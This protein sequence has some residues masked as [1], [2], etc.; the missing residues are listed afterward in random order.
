MKISMLIFFFLY[1]S[2][3]CGAQTK[4]PEYANFEKDEI[5]LKVCHF[6]KDA[7][8]V[9][10]FDKA[11]AGYNDEHNLVT[12]RRIRFKILREKGIEKA[13]IQIRYYSYENFET[14]RGLQASIFNI[15]DEKGQVLTTLDKK[16]VYDKKLNKYYSELSFTMPKVKVG[17]IIDYKYESVM[18]N[19]GALRE[20][21]FQQEIP[22]MLSSYHLSIIPN[23]E[24]AWSVYKRTSIPIDIK[25]D[26]KGGTILFEMKNLPGL[27]NEA[28][29]ASARDYLQRVNFQFS[30][31]TNYYGKQNYSTTWKELSKELLEDKDFGSQIT[32]NLSNSDIIKSLC[33]KASSPYEKMRI[34]H[35]YVRFNINWNNIYSKYATE[36]IKEPWEKKTGNSGEINL[37]LINL[38]KSEGLD[39][40][41]L[42]V[43]ERENGKIDSTYPFVDQFNKVAA[44]VNI[45]GKGYILDGTDKQTPSYMVP[46]EFLNTIAF[47]VAKKNSTLITIIDP[48]RKKKNTIVLKGDIDVSG[49]MKGEVWVNNYDYSRLEKK[50]KYFKNK[51]KYKDEEFLKPYAAVKID[52]FQINDLESDSLPLKHTFKL[53]YTLDKSGDYYLLNYNLFTGFEKNPFLAEQRFS[54]IDFGCKY[55][56]ILDGNF[57]LPQNLVSESIPKNMKLVSP[58]NSMSVSRQIE[59]NSN[60]LRIMLKIEFNKTEY[61]ADEYDM[62][63]EFYKK[64]MDV[65]SEPVVL[66]TK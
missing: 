28:Y 55:L 51:Q 57:N 1:V 15:D 31:F 10:I 17:S 66:K 36:G 21:Y 52:S 12:E 14:I 50:V 41:P 62:V 60:S 49:T 19:Y 16:L 11:N 4:I 22:V 53:N 24:F 45:N 38:L 6:D 64:M 20:W 35:D 37:I 27:R 44:Y 59:L 48:D 18:K 46:F 30:G 2:A 9:I 32:K 13:N 47:M 26:P 3:F 63:Q 42:L 43:S 33:A 61:L 29:M 58:D 25:P 7:D 65:L 5:E 40:F 54:N 39:V 34:I 23:A 8:A 56:C